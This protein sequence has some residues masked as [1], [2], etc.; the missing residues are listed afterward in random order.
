MIFWHYIGK[1]IV[2]IALLCVI[3]SLPAQASPCRSLKGQSVC[4]LDIQRSAKN[5]WEYRLKIKI[6][7]ITQPVAIYNCRDRFSQT[8]DGEKLPFAPQGVGDWVCHLLEK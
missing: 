4:I 1:I 2:L 8:L 6:D 7:Q 3:Y 5:H